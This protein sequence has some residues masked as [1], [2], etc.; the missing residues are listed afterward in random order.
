MDEFLAN[1]YG[2]GGGNGQ[3]SDADALEKMAQLTL[4]TKQAEEEGVDISDLSEEELDELAEELYGEGGDVL[5]KEAQTKFE[6]S[7][8]L[9]RVMA[10]SMWQELDSIQKEARLR[11]LPKRVYERT[12][13]RLGTRAQESVMRRTE[14]PTGR[15]EQLIHYLGGARTKPGRRIQGPPRPRSHE[16]YMRGRERLARAARGAAEIGAPALGAA[17]LAGGAGV[18]PS[19]IRKVRELRKG[20]S[21]SAFQA[22]IEAR[23]N[24]MLQASGYLNKTASDFDMVVDQAALELLEA[25]GYPVEWAE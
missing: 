17:A 3:T 11:D 5:E 1:Y 2:T 9:G 24:E 6:E 20:S 14:A 21:D 13:G 18:T 10:H 25:N 8:F 23:A 15:M 16:T 4:L 19:A 12:L 22:L 7:D